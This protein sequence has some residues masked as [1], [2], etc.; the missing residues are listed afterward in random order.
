M[1]G[2]FYILTATLCGDGKVTE[3]RETLA[4]VDCED[5][6]WSCSPYQRSLASESLSAQHLGSLS[7]VCPIP[8]QSSGHCLPVCLCAS[9]FWAFLTDG[10]LGCAGS[11]M[12]PFVW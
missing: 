6:Q 3:E 1:V 7:A 12:A 10:I 8:T 4:S 11:H 9:L 5:S 2:T